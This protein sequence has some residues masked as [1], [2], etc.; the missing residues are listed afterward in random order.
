LTIS[1]LLD[2]SLQYIAASAQWNQGAV[3]LTDADDTEN[4]VNAE[5]NI[6][7][8]LTRKR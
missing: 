1:D 5:F 8:L 7:C 2:D 6:N 3:K 4:T